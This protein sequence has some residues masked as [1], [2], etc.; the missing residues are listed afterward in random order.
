MENHQLA[1]CYGVA[2]NYV[3]VAHPSLP[4]Y[5]AYDHS[6]L[7]RMEGVAWGL[8]PLTANDTQAAVMSDFFASG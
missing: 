5:L 2:A 4:S 8:D 3:S 7:L 6:S 1:A